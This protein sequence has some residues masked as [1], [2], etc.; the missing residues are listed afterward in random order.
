MKLDRIGSPAEVIC[1]VVAYYFIKGKNE[2]KALQ[3]SIFWRLSYKH[4]LKGG[5]SSIMKRTHLVG[6]FSVI[7]ITVLLVLSGCTDSKSGSVSAKQIISYEDIVQVL[8]TMDLKPT[9]ANSKGNFLLNGTKNQSIKLNNGNVIEVYI[10][11]N[12]AEASIAQDEYYKKTALVEYKVV[13]QVYATKNCLLLYYDNQF[14]EF[15]QSL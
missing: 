7:T 5:I 8:K 4:G 14:A 15:L 10:Y 9:K 11:K 1:S 3:I 6:L 12:D 2:L 13:P